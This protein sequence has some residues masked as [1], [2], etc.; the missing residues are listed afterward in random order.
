MDVQML[1]DPNRAGDY[2]FSVS[3]ILDCFTGYTC[4]NNGYGQYT[5]PVA[6]VIPNIYNMGY[7]TIYILHAP[8]EVT[9]VK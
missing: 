6:W 3:H 9:C 4:A 5:F 8:S 1:I 2:V 7:I